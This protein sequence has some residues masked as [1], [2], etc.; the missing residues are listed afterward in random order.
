MGV[1]AVVRQYLSVRTRWEDIC[2]RCTLCCHER[3]VD[4]DGNVMVDWCAPCEFLDEEARACTVYDRRLDACDR[5]RKVGLR[6]ALFDGHL[7]P[8]CA[9]VRMFRPLLHRDH[10]AR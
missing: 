8:S 3:D 2:D 10:P 6:S 7:P 9:Y 4:P 1:I 5:C